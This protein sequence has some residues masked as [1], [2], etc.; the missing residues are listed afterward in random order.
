MIPPGEHYVL[1]AENDGAPYPPHEGWLEWHQTLHTAP[2]YASE[3]SGPLVWETY[4][5]PTGSN[6]AAVKECAARLGDRYGKVRI[7]RLEFLPEDA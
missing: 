1:V 5:Q 2:P 7:A 4:L 6:L 3:R